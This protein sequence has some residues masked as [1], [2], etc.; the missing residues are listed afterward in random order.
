MVVSDSIPV[1]IARSHGWP[2]PLMSHIDGGSISPWVRRPKCRIQAV[3]SARR[4]APVWVTGL[5]GS[6]HCTRARMRRM[7]SMFPSAMASSS[8]AGT[9]T[10]IP[11]VPGGRSPASS[12]AIA[13]S[14]AGD[15]AGD[16]LEVAERPLR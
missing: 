6:A 2:M 5:P 8:A 10:R 15:R 13:R 12:P 16:P 4:M 7:N 3:V 9:V 14:S 1:S 11:A